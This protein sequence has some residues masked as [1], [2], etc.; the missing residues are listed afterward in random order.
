MGSKTFDGTEAIEIT[1]G[2]LGLG[3]AMKFLGTTTTAISDGSTTK[4]IMIN[5]KTTTAEAGNVVL[6]NGYEYV[7]TGSAWE[8]LG[9]EGSFKVKQTAVASPSAN[10]NATAF[11]DTITQDANGNI[12][13]TKKNVQFP[14]TSINGKTGAITLAHQPAGTISTPTFTGTSASHKHSF[15]GT[16]ATHGHT[17]TG[18][19]S[20]HA[21]TFTG[22]T[23]THGHTFTG[24]GTLIQGSF[25]GTKTTASVSYQP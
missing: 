14:V 13:A 2:D 19:S 6:Y 15:T 8:Q 18:T 5:S 21:H 9:Q 10:G 12:T 4:S 24:T 17:F 23:S 11:I 22:T 20:S 3:Q 1:A 25:S 7:W 16:T